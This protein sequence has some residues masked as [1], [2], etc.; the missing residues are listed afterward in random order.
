MRVTPTGTVNSATRYQRTGTRQRTLPRARSTTPSRPES[1]PVT[2][3]AP[4][5]RAPLPRNPCS[6]RSNGN[7]SA[8]AMGRMAAVRKPAPRPITM[9]TSTGWSAMT[10]S[11]AAINPFCR[12]RSQ[13]ASFGRASGVDECQPAPA[14][15]QRY[16]P[17]RHVMQSTFR[18][19]A[20]DVRIHRTPCWRSTPD[21]ITQARCRPGWHYS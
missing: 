1:A 6:G 7:T 13:G 21:V 15:E 20:Q 17:G 11:S 18:G 9:N 12:Y 3:N 10:R 4:R 5:H 8:S 2:T 19:A 14:T 16:L